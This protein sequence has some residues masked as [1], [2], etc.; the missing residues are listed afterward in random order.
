MAFTKI[1][2]AGIGSTETVTVDGLTVINNGS[3]GGNLSV[4]G[5]LTYE[6]VTNVDSVGLI[7]A[8][9]GIN[10]G[11]GITLSPDG[12]IFAT[13]LSTYSG[14][15]DFNNGINV[16]SNVTISDSIVHDGNT[17]T[18]IRFP[19]GNTISAEIN[20]SE[21][22]R[23]GAGGSVGIGTNA[24]DTILH[25]QASDGT[26]KLITF[27]GGNSKRNNYIGITG[28]D[29]LEI[30]VDENNE[31][32]GSTLRLRIDGGEKARITSGGALLVGHDSSTGS[33]KLQTFTAGQDGIDI[34][35]Y[36]STAANGGRLT[37]Y[38]S[39]NATIGSNTEVADN[40]SLGRIDWR[41]YNDDGTAYNIGATIEAE[42]DGAVDSVTD[43][44]SA[45][46]FKTSADGSSSPTERLRID[47]NGDVTIG[48]SANAG[49]NRLIV[50]ESHTEAFVN[51]T[52][53]TLRITND[54]TSANNNQTSI[55]F[56]CS[57][58]GSGADSA[59][60]SQAEDASGNSRLEFWTDTSN[61]MTEKMSITSAGK[62][63]VGIQSPKT[64]LD[65]ANDAGG[66]LT[67]TCSD[68]SSSADQLIGK[69][70]FYNADPSGDG[71]QNSVNISAHSVSN[72]GS[73]AYLKFSTA[74]GDTGSEGAD[75]VERLRIASAGNLEFRNID[76][77]AGTGNVSQVNWIGPYVY[78]HS[79]TV[80]ATT[81][82]SGAVTFDLGCPFYYDGTTFEYFI[83][84]SPTDNTNFTTTYQKGFFTKARGGGIGQF[85]VIK[86]D[87]AKAG[88]SLGTP[89]AGNPNGHQFNI[90]ISGA[91]ANKEYRATI[92]YTGISRYAGYT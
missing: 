3:F 52:D 6:D 15:A 13:G 70:N 76:T 34:I 77:A 33:G 43:M 27:N 32:S 26:A 24:P 16:L 59:I 17:D 37:F 29:N 90:A 56:T 87:S 2:A 72:T 12:N 35:G 38:R 30:G 88:C 8:R 68:D 11:S 55:S 41:G 73:G 91:V 50:S 60:V 65:I 40:D 10:V 85:E 5:T 71:P 4:G 89:T 49:G 54:D 84:A 61:G 48:G 25:L 9:S 63:G 57:S 92:L 79:K 36:N 51:P 44:P 14:L 21:A 74:S 1:A 20:G 83:N 62:V 64:D 42:V 7:T 47:S 75:G 45:L 69:I 78:Q 28:S 22:L 81:N 67:L 82:G 39:K 23:V 18:K 80:T 53:S 86:N 46:F 19:E 66:T 31:G 58:T